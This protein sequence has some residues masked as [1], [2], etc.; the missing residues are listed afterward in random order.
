[1]GKPWMKVAGLTRIFLASV[2]LMI[3]I[4]TCLHR[5][6]TRV[7]LKSVNFPHM[8]Q[9][10]NRSV[11]V[12]RQVNSN[13]L[14]SGPWREVFLGSSCLTWMHNWSLWKQFWQ[15][16]MLVRK[17]SGQNSPSML[18]VIFHS[19]QISNFSSSPLYSNLNG[20]FQ[21]RSSITEGPTHSVCNVPAPGFSFKV[22]LIHTMQNCSSSTSV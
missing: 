19:P 7:V 11:R 21:K 8:R 9:N 2:C 10:V 6:I 18:E 14:F 17:E 16:S 20:N 13:R 22:S 3:P 12:R 15:K 5:I 4:Q 1:M